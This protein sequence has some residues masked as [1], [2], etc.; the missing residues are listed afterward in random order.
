ML[1]RFLLFSLGLSLLS[2][3]Q[4]KDDPYRYVR[5][6]PLGPAA[7]F[8]E[9]PIDKDGVR[10]M[11][12][13]EPGEEPPRQAAAKAEVPQLQPLSLALDMFSRYTAFGPKVEKIELT[14]A[15]EAG[16]KAFYSFKAP[17]AKRSLAVLYRDHQ[18]LDWFNT[19]SLV[20]KDDATTFPVGSMRF[21]N[22]SDQTLGLTF[23]IK[24]K[25]QRTKV[26]KVGV[27]PGRTH[28]RKLDKDGELVTIEIVNK[29][30]G[31][32]IEI[33]HST[34]KADKG[35]RINAFFYKDTKPKA[36]KP[37]RYLNFPEKIPALPMLSK[38]KKDAGE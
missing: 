32:N 15:I 3:G 37:V 11:L 25:G 34:E 13:P 38:P 8:R 29:G 14:A 21:V 23:T 28:I 36:F 7:P 26:A 12:E 30:G 31:E 24:K 6:L 16:G 19:K 20:L 33:R 27:A 9:G 1:I 22:V 17:T 2:K 4:V 35:E 5:I 18:K 10:I